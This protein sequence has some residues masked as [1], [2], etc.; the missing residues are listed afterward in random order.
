MQQFILRQMKNQKT[1][2]CS[3]D[4]LIRMPYFCHLSVICS[5]FMMFILAIN[6]MFNNNMQCN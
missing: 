1:V 6:A 4:K 5:Q 2:A 3:T